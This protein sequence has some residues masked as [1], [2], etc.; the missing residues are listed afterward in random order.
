MEFDYQ[1]RLHESNTYMTGALALAMIMVI[2]VVYV[3]FIRADDGT[4]MGSSGEGA[5]SLGVNTTYPGTNIATD[6]TQGPSDNPG[7][8][9]PGDGEEVGTSAPLAGP[10]GGATN[11]QP[12]KKRVAFPGPAEYPYDPAHPVS[13]PADQP[14]GKQVPPGGEPVTSPAIANIRN[15]RR[16]SGG[17]TKPPYMSTA[18]PMV[19]KAAGHDTKAPTPP[20]DRG[21]PP[22]PEDEYRQQMDMDDM[23]GGSCPVIP[24]TGK[25]ELAVK[26]WINGRRHGSVVMSDR[27]VDMGRDGGWFDVDGKGCC[28]H[29]CRK[30]GPSGVAGEYWSCIA[31]QTPN[32]EYAKLSPRGM[33]CSTFAGAPIARGFHA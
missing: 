5:K 6:T 24:A 19:T 31:P 15:M 14:P 30:V 4:G 10:R 12:V 2:G 11:Q 13:F 25:L 1:R 28:D 32:S 33:Q 3:V 9:Q 26:A 29:Y 21:I 7:T 22:T 20:P 23:A 8:P 27:H 16:S 18:A 17:A